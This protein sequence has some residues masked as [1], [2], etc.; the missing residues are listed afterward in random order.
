MK[1]KWMLPVVMLVV[2]ALIAGAWMLLMPESLR[3][4]QVAKGDDGV[5]YTDYFSS[6]AANPE[7]VVGWSNTLVSPGTVRD[8]LQL[9]GTAMAPCTAML[10]ME[11]PNQFDMYFTVEIQ[12]RGGDSRDPGVFFCVDGDYQQRY[13]LMFSDKKLLLRYNGVQEV[14]VKKVEDLTIGKA[15]AVRLSVH[16]GKL[17][18]YINGAEEPNLKFNAGGDY[19]SFAQARYFGVIS[20][21]REAYFDNL[22][23]TNGVDYIPATE[24]AVYGKDEVKTIKGLGNSLQM[25]VFLDPSN[26]SD[27]AFLWSVDNEQIATI[28]QDGLLTATG[29]G[30]VTVTAATRDGSNLSASCKIKIGVGEQAE[31]TSISTNRPQVLTESGTLALTGEEPGLCVLTS[32]RILLSGE[33]TEGQVVCS[34]DGG[35]TWKSVFTGDIR[36]GH[37]FQ[38]GD[39]VYLIGED[40]GDGSLVI[41]VSQDEGSTWS[42]KSVLDTRK[43]SSAPSAVLQQNGCVYMT[44]EVESAAAVA[45][46][47]SGNAALAPILLKAPVGSDLTKPESWTFSEELAYG[48]IL[49][50]GAA[51]AVDYVDVPNSYGDSKQVGWAAGNV[52]QVHDYTSSWYDDTMKT[53]Y[54]YLHGN[55]GTQGYALLLKVTENAKG[56][57]KPALMTAPKSNKILL[58]VPMPGGN[59]RF[60]IV[61][62]AE[63]ELYWQA[64]SYLNRDERIALYFSRNGYDWCF[65]GFA[66]QAQDGKI[67]SPS[68]TFDG[69]DLLVA[70][71][72]DEEVLFYRVTDYAALVY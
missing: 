50:D 68:I 27:R 53:F 31:D 8:S 51:S 10:D 63:T 26:A 64:S 7:W 2:I 29:Y 23:I 36:F 25:Q 3:T 48:D 71:Q 72:C 21:A 39:N 13:Q 6:N 35:N 4:A 28:N 66:A 5:L 18:V 54:I 1:N 12:E 62:D 19:E 43:W 55:R 15:Y 20:Y 45:N 34:D 9:S 49:K 14:A 42:G 38:V 61:Y 32:G 40:S 24:I 41:Y 59:D 17:E 37:V 67:G 69:K 22:V 56:E 33:G 30:T 70:A 46:G 52:F 44:M 60:S 58:F 16:G 65:A 57:L 47:Y 11:L